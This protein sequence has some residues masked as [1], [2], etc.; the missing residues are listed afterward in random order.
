MTRSLWA[1][2]MPSFGLLSAC[3][4]QPAYRSPPLASPSAWN[5]DKSA[6]E[7]SQ[8]SD[9]V[10]WWTG[11]G[12][13]QVNQFVIAGLRDNPTFAE[14]MARL[15]QARAALQI[16]EAQRLP[17]VMANGN[18]TQSQDRNASGGGTMRQTTGG[19]GATLT[20]ELDLWGRIRESRVAAESRLSART[21]DA[22]AILLTIAGDIA[23]TAL[24]LKTCKLVLEIRDRDIRSREIELGIFRTRLAFGQVAPIAIA[25]AQSNLALVRTQRITQEEACLRL[26]NALVA[27]TGLDAR[28][29]DA[30]LPPP[31]AAA[32]SEDP[33]ASIAQPPPFVPALPATVL[34]G[35][36]GVVA[37]EREVAARWSQ[38]AMARAERLPRINL[39]AIL[40]GQWISAFGSTDTYASGSAG[41]AF[42]MPVFDGGA[43]AAR[44]GESAAAYRE[45]EARLI[46]TVRAAVRDVEDA[47]TAQQSA[48]AR[49]QSAREAVDA[50]STTLTANTA[51]FDAGSIAQFELEESRRQFNAAKEGE[52]VAA[53]DRA[54]AWVSLVRR[55]GPSWNA[56][57]ERTGASFTPPETQSLASRSY[58]P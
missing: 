8:L 3:A 4:T 53:F 28:S 40:T 58:R 5:G 37:A 49:Q 51:R 29:I 47:L 38:I 45:A 57:V 9:R 35:H 46:L 56:S 21:A 24:A 30:L 7:P 15:D 32:V 44:V 12:D 14:V 43:G 55:T 20:W 6:S 25:T 41:A 18:V 27:L 22:Q 54:R 42:S 26:V 16:S 48:I 31:G 10:E 17:G 50:A 19:L 33:A 13:A 39:T 11:L 2:F 23:D 34:M 36:P 52:V 1:I